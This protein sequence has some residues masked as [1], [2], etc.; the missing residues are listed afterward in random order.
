MKSELFIRIKHFNVYANWCILSSSFTYLLGDDILMM[1]N[2]EEQYI[3]EL[4]KSM[5]QFGQLLKPYFRKTRS[6]SFF[7]F[8]VV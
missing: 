6:S 3:D 2:A 8:K 1:K 7:V 5:E 4:S